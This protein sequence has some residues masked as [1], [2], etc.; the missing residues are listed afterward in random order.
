MGKIAFLFSGQGA[1]K[2]GMGQQLASCSQE[3]AKVFAMADEI[4]P[5]T[6]EQCFH[7]ST[8]ELLATRNTQPCLFC[9]DLAAAVALR[10]K[11]IKADYLAGFSLGE[12]PALAYG[13]YLSPEDA[14]RFVIKR[15]EYMDQCC[16]DYPGVMFAVVKIPTEVVEQV[17]AQVPGSYPVNYNEKAQTVVACTADAAKSFE[18]AVKS[19][20]G[21]ALRLSVSGG[22]HSPMMDDAAEKLRRDFPELTLNKPE[23]PVIANVTAG[24][25]TDAE[26][27]LQQV[28]RPV[29]W[30]KTVEYLAKEG[31]DTFIEVGIG[32]T[33]ANLVGK[34]LPDA[35]VMN[36]EDEASLQEVLEVL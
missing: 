20:G 16:K 5:G 23:I 15:A 1:Q 21:R 25:Y 19:A 6:S 18:E 29:Y 17:S 33:L 31:V 30:Q 2:T 34:I 4:R 14:F 8:E 11:G 10:E 22:F 12:L 3:A 9:V 7:G 24:E 26:L 32:K 28:H 35:K 27:L 13:G 36:V